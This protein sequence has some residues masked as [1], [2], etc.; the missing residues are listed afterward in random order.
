MFPQIH[1]FEHFYYQLMP[2]F[3]GGVMEL[4][5]AQVLIEKVSY[6][7][8]YSLALLLVHSVYFLLGSR[9][10]ISQLHPLA[11]CCHASSGIMASHSGPIGQNK[12]ILP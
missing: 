9:D 12:L 5:G 11:V 7:R 8:A 4:L 3:P 1:V 2:L 10:A 6:L